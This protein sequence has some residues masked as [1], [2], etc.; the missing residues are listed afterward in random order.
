MFS[1]MAWFHFLNGWVVVHCVFTYEYVTYIC[2]IFLMHSSLVGHLGCFCICC[3]YWVTKSCPTLFDPMD[4]RTPGFPVLP[5]GTL[6]KEA[7]SSWTFLLPI[8]RE[9]FLIFGFFLITGRK[10][11]PCIPEDNKFCLNFWPWGN[12]CWSSDV[13]PSNLSQGRIWGQTELRLV[14]AWPLY[15]GWLWGSFL[16]F[17][18]PPFPSLKMALL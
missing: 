5:V 16:H 17:S 2:L 3:C 13:Y 9:N 4:C 6:T 7:S 14:P 12:H 15:A 11:T 10:H 18:E 8:F 1:Q